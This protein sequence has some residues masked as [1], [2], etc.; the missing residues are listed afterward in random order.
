[1]IWDEVGVEWERWGQGHALLVEE[2]LGQNFGEFLKKWGFFKTCGNGTQHTLTV[3]F[4]YCAHTRT[5][6]P[7]SS[8]SFPGHSQRCSVKQR[9]VYQA[10][11]HVDICR[12]TLD[13][14]GGVVGLDPNRAE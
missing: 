3:V 9:T 4:S 1:M 13:N 2:G 12:D 6:T 10:H 8:L 7:S 5:P 11:C 14:S